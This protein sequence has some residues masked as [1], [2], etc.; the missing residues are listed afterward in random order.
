[1]KN[2]IKPLLF[3]LL[4]Q[5]TNLSAQDLVQKKPEKNIPF[6]V[7]Q[8]FEA[9]FP[10][11]DPIWFSQYQGRYNEQLVYEGRFIFDNR[12]SSAIYDRDGQL[13]AFA[14]TIEASEIPEKAIEYMKKNYTNRSITEAIM[15]TRAKDETTI[16]LGIYI[17]NQMRIIVFDKKG[18]FI[19]STRG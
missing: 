5:F 11:N 2:L 12:Y 13:I 3:L 15:V 8:S 1:M 4:F 10:N 6:I 19:K 18:E 14:A 9:K 7:Q 17:D 16:E